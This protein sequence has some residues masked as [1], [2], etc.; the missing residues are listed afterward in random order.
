MNSLIAGINCV[1]ASPRQLPKPSRLGQRVVV[2]DIAF[3]SEAGGHSFETVTWPFINALGPRLLAW[4]DHHDSRHH[5]RFAEDPRFVLHRKSEHGACPELVTPARV[6]AVGTVDT[7][8][9]H[10]DFDGL[11]SAAK[12]LRGG[13][14]PYPDS[15]ADAR[16]I[17]TR[18]GV[19]GPLGRLL[20]RALRALP[21]D[22]AL[23]HE[24]LAFLAGG[25]ADPLVL[26][27]L[28]DAG[29]GLEPLEQQSETLA[30]GYRRLSPDLVLVD[31][32]DSNHAFDKTWL[33]LLGQQQARIAVVIDRAS[34]SF[35]AAFDSGVDFLASFG[36]SGGMPT[37]VSLQREHLADCL[38]VL[39]V[40]PELAAEFVL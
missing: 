7:L 33:L 9:C 39:G 22:Q 2:L 28:S 34:V 25:A 11:C 30:R 38:L 8:V 23:R 19:P 27:R 5:A 20:D 16:A 17:D 29:A 12:W 10:N 21:R 37:L 24:V 1:L 26:A 3:A 18:I 35:A 4:I 6:Q 14:E 13:H 36:L 32:S 40:S 31:A 15:D